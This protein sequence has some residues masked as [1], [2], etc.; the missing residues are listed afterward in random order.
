MMAGGGAEQISSQRDSPERKGG[1][2]EKCQEKTQWSIHASSDFLLP[3]DPPTALPSVRNA[4]LPIQSRYG[5][6]ES[7]NPHILGIS[8]EKL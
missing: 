7:S 5:Y 4:I 8:G 2:I 3:Q 1:D 6:T